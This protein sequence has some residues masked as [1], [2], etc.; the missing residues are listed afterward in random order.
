MGI[1]DIVNKGKGLFNENKDKVEGLLHSEKAEQV[2]DSVLDAGSNL[3][4][5]I[6]PD[7]FDDSIDKVRE[8]IDKHIGNE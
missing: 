2:S 7:K 6:T 4:K 8:N 3:A 1:E 5:K